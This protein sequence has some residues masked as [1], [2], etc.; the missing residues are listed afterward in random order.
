MALDYNEK[1]NVLVLGTKLG[2]IRFARYINN[3]FVMQKYVLKNL[4]QYGIVRVRFL[5]SIDFI[6]F[7]D[8]N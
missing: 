6:L 5:G 2:E 1:E 7:V 3:K 4:T 8:E